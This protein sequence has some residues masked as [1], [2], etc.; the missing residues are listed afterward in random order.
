MQ[1]I[2]IIDGDLPI[3]GEIIPQ[4]VSPLEHLQVL[5]IIRSQVVQ[6]RVEA[7]LQVASK[8]RHLSLA[9]N[10][11]VAV[12]AAVSLLE[13]LEELDLRHNAIT[14]LSSLLSRLSRLRTLKLDHNRIRQVK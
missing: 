13:D 7:M 1:E 9:H 5:H 8:L 11:L 6:V 10:K 3:L 4:G 12:P 2:K 14:R